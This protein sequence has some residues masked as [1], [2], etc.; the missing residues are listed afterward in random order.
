MP[1]Y[2]QEESQETGADYG[3]PE[4]FDQIYLHILARNPKI[5]ARRA[6][7]IIGIPGTK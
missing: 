2:L 1:G 4:R 5:T 3:E 7:A 6:V